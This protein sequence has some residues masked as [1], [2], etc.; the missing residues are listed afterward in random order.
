MELQVGDVIKVNKFGTPKYYM[1]KKI[2]E[3]QYLVKKMPVHLVDMRHLPD[4]DVELKF[5]VDWDLQSPYPSSGVWIKGPEKKYIPI[6][7]YPLYD[8]EL[9]SVKHKYPFHNL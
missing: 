8:G 2:T 9:F 7:E 5:W 4:G 6:K 3:T 1:I